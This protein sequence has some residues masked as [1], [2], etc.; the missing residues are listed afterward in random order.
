MNEATAATDAPEA[1]GR[2]APRRSSWATTAETP[3][4]TRSPWPMPW[5]PPAAIPLIAAYVSEELHPFGRNDRRRQRD[6]MNRLHELRHAVDEV[7]P[8]R[9]TDHPVGLR[10]VP[11]L[12]ASLGLH[13][14]AAGEGARAIV[15]GSTHRGPVGRVA[16]GSTAASL[17]LEAPCYV[18]VA[19]LGF[20]ERGRP[21][22]EDRGG[23]RRLPGLPGCPPRGDVADLGRGREPG[24][25]DRGAERSPRERRSARTSNFATTWT[26]CSSGTES[27]TSSGE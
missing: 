10:D 24:G 19:P 1:P 9:R 15:L 6:V 11:A 23:G 5:P 20:R 26:P 18:A 14:L 17:L 12:S 25:A 2:P 8:H 22:R 4:G 13:D 21:V 3:P 27:A 7:L 16:V